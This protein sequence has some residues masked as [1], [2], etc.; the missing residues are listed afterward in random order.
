[1]ER[2]I[3]RVLVAA[4]WLLAPLYL[5]LALL[6]LL[7]WVQFFHELADAF[8]VAHEA[9]SEHLIIVSLTLVDLALIA[10]LIV[11]VM[12][13]GYENYL[14]RLDITR[15]SA[16]FS[17]LA[18]L[19]SGSIKVKL[20]V[21]IVAIS[22]IDLLKVFL[23]IDEV[24]NDKLLWRVII[25]LTFVISALALAALDRLSNVTHKID[26]DHGN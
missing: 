26:A 1:M 16:K 4:R 3:E 18:T 25:H 22:A 21:T 11:M 8:L 17:W 12:L 23:E 2:W 7:F 20:A 9:S 13:S 15:I 5:G 10:G 6:L 24:P 14:S 19:D